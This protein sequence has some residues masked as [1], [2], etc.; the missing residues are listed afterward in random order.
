MT[1]RISINKG[2]DELVTYDFLVDKKIVLGI[3]ATFIYLE[4]KTKGI[5]PIL[6]I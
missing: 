1:R 5:E 3:N 4:V 6:K 2:I